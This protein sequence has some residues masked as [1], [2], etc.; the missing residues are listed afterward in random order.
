[1]S[2]FRLCVKL[3]NICKY[4]TY[5]NQIMSNKNNPSPGDGL[6]SVRTTTLFRAVNFE[7]YA[8]PNAVIMGIGLIAIA[9]CTGYIAYMRS[10]YEG[11][12]YYG[13]IQEDGTE[14]FIKKRSKWD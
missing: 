1:M 11:Q 6:R 7:L 5:L 3:W 10:K 12:G 13:A 8:K 14:H 9:G 2:F 4:Y